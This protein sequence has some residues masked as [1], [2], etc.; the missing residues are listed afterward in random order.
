MCTQNTMPYTGT[1]QSLGG[2]NMWAVPYSSDTD[3]IAILLYHTRVIPSLYIQPMNM[4]YGLYTVDTNVSDFKAV[5][6]QAEIFL[7]L[8]TKMEMGWY[9]RNMMQS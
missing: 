4:Y 5:A 2:Q 7:H 1:E 8:A 6:Y 9:A 3:K